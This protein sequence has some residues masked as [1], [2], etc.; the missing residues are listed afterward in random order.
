MEYLFK[1]V[2]VKEFFLKKMYLAL[3]KIIRYFNMGLSVM[4]NEKLL[5]KMVLC[6]SLKNLPTYPLISLI[7]YVFVFF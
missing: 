6:Y 1:G 7:L 2:D 4:Q 5:N 3:W